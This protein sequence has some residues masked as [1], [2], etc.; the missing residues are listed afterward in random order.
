MAEASRRNTGDTP[1]SRQGWRIIFS[2]HC[3]TTG[4]CRGSCERRFEKQATAE[5]EITKHATTGENGAVKPLTP[6][7]AKTI[8]GDEK[9]GRIRHT[10]SLPRRDKPDER[11]RHRDQSAQIRAGRE[12]EFGCG[13]ATSVREGPVK[14]SEKARLRVLRIRLRPSGVSCG[15]LPTPE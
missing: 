13:E 11:A 3:T 10:Q 9:R 5:H 4:K 6:F 12:C 7:C 14:R 2:R 1:V 8:S 15:A